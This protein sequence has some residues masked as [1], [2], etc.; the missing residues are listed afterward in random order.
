MYLEEGLERYSIVFS[1]FQNASGNYPIRNCPDNVP[2]ISY[3]S[4][5]KGWMDQRV[6]NEMLQ[7]PRFIKRDVYGRKKVYFID[8]VSSHQITPQV[9]EI[10]AQLN[11]EIRFLPHN[12]TDLTQ[13]CDSFVIQAIKAAWMKR[14]DAHKFEQSKSGTFRD[15]AGQAGTIP[16]PQ[17]PFFLKLAADS[18]AEARNRVDKNGLNFSRK[19]MIRCGLSLDTDGIWREEQLKPELQSLLK[20][21]K[22][23]YDDT[24]KQHQELSMRTAKTPGKQASTP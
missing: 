2:G 6:F 14:W 10:L 19:A 23:L 12:S 7:E 4:G 17:K 16:N 3:R 11:V 8:S 21:C 15:G 18:V 22:K 13:P 1:Y 9:E 24:F 5:P 20:K